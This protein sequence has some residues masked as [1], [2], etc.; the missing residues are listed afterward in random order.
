MIYVYIYVCGF[1]KK[2]EIMRPSTLP[3]TSHNH[4]HHHHNTY[5]PLLVMHFQ[6]QRLAA[7]VNAAFAAKF[8]SAAEIEAERE[9]HCMILEY[10]L[11]KLVL[12]EVRSFILVYIYMDVYVR[13]YTID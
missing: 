8:M 2:K 12:P 4:H 6:G 5:S 9:G 7:T 3:A 10:V 13:I 1:K 11:A